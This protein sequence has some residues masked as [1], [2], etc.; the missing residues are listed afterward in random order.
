MEA[1]DLKLKLKSKRLNSGRYQ[2]NFSTHGLSQEYYGYL[3]T[4]PQ[5]SV[6]EVI[7]KIGRHV[8]AMQVSERYYQR[9]L[10][11]IQKRQINSGRILVFKQ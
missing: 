3:L 9:N 11:S 6:R 7:E 1:I 10:F 8:D 5:T 2:V 4:E